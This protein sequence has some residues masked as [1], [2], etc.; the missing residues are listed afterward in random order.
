MDCVATESDLATI[1]IVPSVT[2]IELEA[3]IGPVMLPVLIVIENPFASTVG[4]PTIVKV[5]VLVAEVPV[6]VKVPATKSKSVPATAP[7]ITQYKSSMGTPTPSQ[8]ISRTYAGLVSADTLKNSC[9]IP[10]ESTNFLPIKGKVKIVIVS[11]TVP[12]ILFLRKVITSV[13]GYVIVVD[14][15]LRLAEL[16][17]K[18][19]SSFRDPKLGE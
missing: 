5:P 4:T 16:S 8:Y 18:V 19:P 15:K 12:E 6:G 14:V 17:A 1:G 11:N 2:N 9:S 7:S 3:T 10:F 13:F